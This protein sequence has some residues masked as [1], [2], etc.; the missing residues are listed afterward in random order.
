VRGQFVDRL[1]GAPQRAVHG[2]DDGHDALCVVRRDHLVAARPV[3]C[4]L[5]AWHST[6]R[7]RLQDVADGVEG[8]SRLIAVVT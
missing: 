2:D 1:D 5:P 4:T 6:A 7:G 3:V 8:L